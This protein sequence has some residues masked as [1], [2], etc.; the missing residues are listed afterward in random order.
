MKYILS[1][2]L[3]IL[4]F[5]SIEANNKIDSLF[6]EK[7]FFELR[8]QIRQSNTE[9]QNS[10]DG[11]FY[12][13]FI[14]NA[15]GK[16]KKSDHLINQILSECHSTMP[17]SMKYLLYELLIDNYTKESEY[18]KALSYYKKLNSVTDD[19]ITIS[20]RSSYQNMIQLYEAMAD[21]P[22]LKV[23]KNN[24]EHY[25]P[26]H[27]NG[28][29]HYVV[30]VTINENSENFVFDSG[31][32]MNVLTRS[33]A[34]KMNVQIFDQHQVDVGTSTDHTIQAQIGFSPSVKIGDLELENA[35]FLILPDELLNFS[36]VNY[37]INGII[38]YPV[39]REMEEMIIGKEGLLYLPSSPTVSNVNNIFMDGLSPI[40]FSEFNNKPIQLLFDTGSTG[41]QLFR[42][43]YVDNSKEV[44]ANGEKT[45]ISIGGA[46]GITRVNCYAWKDFPL[47]IA[48]QLISIPLVHIIT[49]ELGNNKKVVDGVVGQN[50]ADQF[51]E[52]VLNLKDMYL[53]FRNK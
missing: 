53:I 36:A 27:R 8:D 38:G 19:S 4:T 18:S 50:V 13:S 16:L 22:P 44:E 51:D 32:N 43:F 52:M 11:K 25:I 34:K 48:N 37:K 23:N 17:D 40:L 3:F 26:L 42:D 45:D 24:K 49:D 30:P 33:M 20:K 9:W 7:R 10:C 21:L 31:A 28:M 14:D 47:K 6:K 35:V 39:M 41:S 2:I 46:G 5:I 12:A 29:G 1:I 15:F